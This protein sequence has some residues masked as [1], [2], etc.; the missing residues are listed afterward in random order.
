MSRSA[1]LL[2]LVGFS[3]LG[4]FIGSISGAEG[5]DAS[6]DDHRNTLTP[7]DADR[8]EQSLAAPIQ[9]CY[10][11]S[12]GPHWNQKFEEVMAEI[13]TRLGVEF[14]MVPAPTRR[15]QSMIDQQQCDLFASV[16]REHAGRYKHHLLIDEPLFDIELNLYSYV[17]QTVELQKIEGPIFERLLQLDQEGVHVGYFRAEG[18][19]EFFKQ[20][21]QGQATPLNRFDQGFH[22]LQRQRIDFYITPITSYLK[23]YYLKDF[24]SQVVQVDSLFTDTISIHVRHSLSHL[25]PELEKIIR[26]LRAEEFSPIFL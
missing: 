23:H 19:N 26:Q 20:F 22:L 16:T 7:M 11:E 21:A 25:K 12:L 4:L 14:R 8:H 3:L 13:F 15:N 1:S 9:F 2:T 5:Y 17:G 24:Q 10:G 6:V 18:L